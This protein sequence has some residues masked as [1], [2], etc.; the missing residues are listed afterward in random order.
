M[1]GGRERGSDDTPGTFGCSVIHKVTH[2]VVMSRYTGLRTPFFNV[3]D[4]SCTL[5]LMQACICTLALH[6]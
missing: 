1:K 6:N 5:A 3:F 4:G 2:P